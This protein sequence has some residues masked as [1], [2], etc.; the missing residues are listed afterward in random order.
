M[1]ATNG[2]EGERRHVKTRIPAH[3]SQI[4]EAR[5]F[6]ERVISEGALSE[7]RAFDL[8]VA[9]SEACASAIER[10]EQDVE[11]AAWRLRDRVVVEISSQGEPGFSPAEADEQRL[12]L[13]L[14]LMTSLADQVQISRLSDHLT[15]VSLTF[16]VDSAC[17]RRDESIDPSD[18]VGE[19][20]ERERLLEDPRVRG[21]V[22]TD[23]ESLERKAAE[24]RLMRQAFR[25]PLT[26]LANRALFFD[27]LANALTRADRRGSSVALVLIDLDDFKKVNDSLGHAGGDRL[28]VELAE[29]LGSQLR[30]E[31]TAARLGGDEFA[32]VLEEGTGVENAVRTVERILADLHIPLILADTSV[33]P[34]ASA[35]LA[36]RPPRG[37]GAEELLQQADLALYA[38]KSDGKNKLRL[39]EAGMCAPTVARRELET[40][41]HQ[42]LMRDE[43]VT[44]YQPILSTRTGAIVGLEALCRWRHP[45]RGLLTPDQFLPAAEETGLI[46]PL[47]DLVLRQACDTV[48]QWDALH[49]DSGLWMAV[50]VCGRQLREPRM[51]DVLMTTLTDSRLGPERLVL[52]I[53]EDVFAVSDEEVLRSL[54]AARQAGVRLAVD[55]FGTGCSS[56][57]LLGK[58][59]ADF[60]K[61]AKPLVDTLGDC[62]GDGMLAD[63]VMGLARCLRKQ[64]VAEGV[65]TREQLEKLTQLGC[66]MWQGWYF[67]PALKC[68]Q[69]LALSRDRAA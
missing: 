29:R 20:S 22:L 25:D 42:A 44:H 38:A 19:E 35:G 33:T 63:A 47:G 27:R 40:D 26:G 56:L 24:A 15:R 10:S 52:D 14:P 34:G 8:E 21:H 62:A 6:V 65:E 45:R 66:D 69:I 23:A 58:H 13:S 5:R 12:T 51:V 16:L 37:C 7:E 39:Y 17:S 59:P 30:A 49:P 67:S 31:D 48:R 2:F 41:L 57:S 50:N 36:V 11:L 43:I 3:V 54:V 9:V 32:L 68:S 46:V 64:V 61:M 55:D 53:N 18:E 4:R 60:L 28:L 1:A